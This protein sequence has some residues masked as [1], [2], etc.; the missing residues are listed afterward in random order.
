MIG[1]FT[2]ALMSPRRATGFLTSPVLSSWVVCRRRCHPIKTA[3]FRAVFVTFTST[4]GLLIL[5]HSSGT[6]TLLKVAQRKETSANLLRARTLVGYVLW[7]MRANLEMFHRFL[8]FSIVVE[9]FLLPV[10]YLSL[11]FLFLAIR[12]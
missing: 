10:S 12:K 5:A 9:T 2:G 3:I 6:M 11:T 8:M 4:V 7:F 1:W